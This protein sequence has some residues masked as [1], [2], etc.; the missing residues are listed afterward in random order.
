MMSKSKNRPDSAIPVHTFAELEEF[1][2]AFADGH[3]K[4]LFI[5]GPPGT[6]KSRTVSR[7]VGKNVFWIDGNATAFGLYLAAF[8]HRDQTIVLDDVDGLYR[9]RSAVRLLKG[10]CQTE[11][12][13]SI[14]WQSN[15]AA[16]DKLGVPRQFTTVSRLI[17]ITNEW[18]SLN[19]NVGAVEDRGHIISFEPSP[20]EIHRHAGGW[21]WNIRSGFITWPGN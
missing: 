13:K 17:V 3:L 4:M 14:S 21:F 10:L 15:A 2:H 18:K 12:T 16:L 11:P 1:I 9:D 6:G 5:L 8:E 7:I 20:L 19:S